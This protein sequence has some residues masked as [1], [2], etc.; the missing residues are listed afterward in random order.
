MMETVYISPPNKLRDPPKDQKPAVIDWN[1]TR[2]IRGQS[3]RAAAKE[4]V[5]YSQTI[6]VTK[7]NYIGPTGTGKTTS[8]I[9]LMHL[10]HELTT[11]L[12]F[13]IKILGKKD[14]E[15]FEETIKTLKTHTIILFDDVSYLRALISRS[16]IE[17]IKQKVTEMRHLPGGKDVRLI[18]ISNFHY[19]KSYDKFLRDAPFTFMTQIGVSE[20]ENVLNMVSKRYA[21]KIKDFKRV[22]R[23][24]HSK[25]RKFTY[26]IG[27]E[28]TF[29]YEFQKPFIPLV[30]WNDISLRHIVSPKREWLAPKCVTCAKGKN[31]NLKSDIP[32]IDFIKE[33]AHKHGKD[34]TKLTIQ[35]K[36]LQ[37]GFNTFPKQTQQCMKAIDDFFENNIMNFTELQESFDLE[38][39]RTLLRKNKCVSVKPNIELSLGEI[40]EFDTQE[41]K[42]HAKEK[43]PRDNWVEP[44]Y[45][46]T[47]KDNLAKYR[48]LHDLYS[49]KPEPSL[50]IKIKALSSVIKRQ[51]A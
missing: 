13:E 24:A 46:Q 15:K 45:K 49:D 23:E 27:S 40:L 2:F 36:L 43:K 34:K 1:G 51:N 42:T 4:I 38:V 25:Q 30:F 8:A 17:L 12:D 5:E 9:C 10:I 31:P 20:N 3:L 32:A 22:F 47:L 11:D 28:K 37:H 50:A 41:L 39:K 6:D 48:E 16:G 18:L 14:L 7:V 29:T 19:S 21:G 44:F 35:I 26:R 33:L